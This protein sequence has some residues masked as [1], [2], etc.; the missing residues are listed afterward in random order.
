MRK[1]NFPNH[2]FRLATR[3]RSIQTGL[4]LGHS[5][6]RHVL[7]VLALEKNVGKN[8]P[9]GVTDAEPFGGLLDGPGRREAVEWVGLALYGLPV[10]AD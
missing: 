7:S 4:V 6:H 2:H 5:I 10:D 9:V 3:G 8:L 1:T